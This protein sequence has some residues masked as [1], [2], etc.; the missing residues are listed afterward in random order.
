MP[1]PLLATAFDSLLERERAMSH[2]LKRTK[3]C[4]TLKVWQFEGVAVADGLTDSAG[5][6][7]EPGLGVVLKIGRMLSCPEFRFLPS[8][9]GRVGT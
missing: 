6:A 9:S 7:L 2:R 1:I 3:R 4:V 5:A 8:V